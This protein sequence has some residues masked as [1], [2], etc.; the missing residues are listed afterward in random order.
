MKG[1]GKAVA[2][3]ASEKEVEA[4]VDIVIRHRCILGAVCVLNDEFDNDRKLVIR[5]TM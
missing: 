2:V 4:S 5:D 3:E 1:K